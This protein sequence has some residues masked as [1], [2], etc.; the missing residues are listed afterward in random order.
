MFQF[1]GA[2]MTK[3]KKKESETKQKGKKLKRSGLFGG[4]NPT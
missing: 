4:L 3:K 2:K 1:C